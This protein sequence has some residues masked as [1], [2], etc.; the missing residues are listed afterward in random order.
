MV[1]SLVLMSCGSAW[2]RS[3]GGGAL[4]LGNLRRT[5]E[6]L[7]HLKHA[8]IGRVVPV[9]RA[10]QLSELINDIVLALRPSV[11]AAGK[12]DMDCPLGML[13]GR[14]PGIFEKV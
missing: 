9:K 14:V 8:S 13:Q 4:A 7:K 5:A 2:T 10:F 12:L 6:M 11:Q 1:K 3:K